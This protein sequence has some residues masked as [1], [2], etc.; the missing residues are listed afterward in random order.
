[1]SNYST[2]PSLLAAKDLSFSL[3]QRTILDN[4]SFSIH[5]G[6]K[7]GLVGRNGSGKTTLLKILSGDETPDTGKIDKKRGISVGY[8]SQE[9]S[10]DDKKTVFENIRDGAKELQKLIDEYEVLKDS[11]EHRHELYEE[12]SYKDGWNLHHRIN[13]II[14]TMRLPNGDTSILGL[15]G[16]EKRRI[17]LAKAIIGNPDLL[18]LDEPTNHLDTD[19]VEWLEK[20]LENYMG[21]C[22]F[23][24]HD[25]YFLDRIATRMLE[26][27]NGN[28]HSYSGNYTEFLIKKAQREEHEERNEHNRQKF[29]TKELEWIARSPQGRTTK[30]RGR[31]Q[32]FESL[33]SQESVGRELDVDMIIPTPPGLSDRVLD[34]KKLGHTIKEKRLFSDLTMSFKKGMRLGIV[35]KNGAGKSTLLKIIIGQL[36]PDEGSV[37]LAARTEINYADQ[38]K[39]TLNPDNT[40]INEVSDSNETVYIG[41]K[42]IPTRAYLKRFLFNDQQLNSYIKNLSGGERSRIILAKI[43]KKGGNFLIL[44]EP[45]NDLDLSTLRVLEEALVHFDGCV[46]VVSHDRYFLNRVCTH[47]LG[48]EGDGKTRFLAG[49]YD[50]YKKVKDGKVVVEVKEETKTEEPKIEAKKVD[51]E[52]QK[53]IKRIE[54]QIKNTEEEIKK[55]EVKFADPKLYESPNDKVTK[56]TEELNGL[57]GKVKEL[58]GKWEEIYRSVI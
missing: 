28:L 49:D 54:T 36:Q 38:E 32:R 14:N 35:G 45:T 47:I 34:L 21:A 31:V 3:G 23:V 25:R 30:S 20:Y 17:N 15:S 50:L 16:G 5:E 44:D 26:L 56:M 41:G 9:F 19:N 1:M 55:L 58:Y 10:L 13:A 57:K 7:I 2:T 37:D 33:A 52:T 6:E 39:L 46:I 12:I 22:L 53:E 24:T 40:V 29:L 43:L 18:I 48:F 27:S 51:Y 4:I 11:D 8:L 42:T